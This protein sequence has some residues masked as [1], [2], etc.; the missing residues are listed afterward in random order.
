MGRSTQG[1]E[2]SRIPDRRKQPLPTPVVSSTSAELSRE[3]P[4]L[5]G[6]RANQPVGQRDHLEAG[7]IG[8]LTSFFVPIVVSLETI[9][10]SHLA[11]H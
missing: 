5:A 10:L 7:S 9:R 4:V 1:T 3:A 6:R 2:T 8:H 11:N